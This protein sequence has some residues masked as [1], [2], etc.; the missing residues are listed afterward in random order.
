[1][2]SAGWPITEATPHT[3][4]QERFWQTGNPLAGSR[5]DLK[6]INLSMSV[7]AIKVV[8]VGAGHVGRPG[9]TS[10]K[11]GEDELHDGLA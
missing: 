7:P 8:D 9:I 4:A 1:M 3:S 10:S 6:A 11:G 5:S 2:T